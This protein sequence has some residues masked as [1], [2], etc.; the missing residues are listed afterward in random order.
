VRGRSFLVW[1]LFLLILPPRATSDIRSEALL[2]EYMETL[3]KQGKLAFTLSDRTVRDGQYVTPILKKTA[4][5]NNI[6]RF[7]RTD[8]QRPTCDLSQETMEAVLQL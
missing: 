3:T 8:H 7:G 5:K 2:R 1:M 4:G 6:P